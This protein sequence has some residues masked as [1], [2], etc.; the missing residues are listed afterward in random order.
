[1]KAATWLDSK[2]SLPAANLDVSYRG[3]TSRFEISARLRDEE[4][5][6]PKAW[7]MAVM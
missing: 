1:M 2:L 5:N 3:F 7:M 6:S 4:F